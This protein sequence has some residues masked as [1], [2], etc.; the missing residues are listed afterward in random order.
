MSAVIRV[1][2]LVVGYDGRPVAGPFDLELS[3]DRITWLVGPNGVGKTTLLKTLGG[4]LVPLAGSIDPSSRPGR[5]GAVY[6]HPAPFLF[7]GSVRDNMRLATR[8]REGEARRALDRLGVARLWRSDTRVLS[9]GQRQRVG[10][11]RALAANPVLLLVDEPEGGMD[12]DAVE[13]WRAV[14]QDATTHGKPVVVVAAHRPVA[15]DGVPTAV[16]SVTSVV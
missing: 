16:F 2:Q 5:D 6:V 12:A 11:A 7:T 1:R 4:L 9:S 10:I 15:L 14:M 8:G 13:C 3:G